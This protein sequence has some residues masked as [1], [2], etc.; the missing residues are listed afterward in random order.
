VP[1]NRLTRRQFLG[2]PLAA[3]VIGCCS[4]SLIEVPVLRLLDKNAALSSTEIQAFYDTVWD[5]AA[6]LFQSCEVA[7]RTIEKV[8]EIRRY[9]SGRPRF[10][11]L[12]RNMMNVVLTETVPLAWD[13][14]RSLCGL[15]T[16]YEGYHLSVLA[17]RNAYPNRLPILAVNTVVHEMLHVLRGD[18]FVRRAG[19][20]N[21]ADREAAVD[22][23]ATQLWL[24]GGLRGL[25]EWANRYV[26]ALR[27]TEPRKEQM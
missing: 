20:L 22:W 19:F 5:E 2:T 14:G 3:P 13:N 9:P 4:T 12:E 17:L 15:T 18:I 6:R 24:V 10:L 23:Q 21:G 7:L 8:G 11:G 16:I 1:A 27:N 26:Q 25:K